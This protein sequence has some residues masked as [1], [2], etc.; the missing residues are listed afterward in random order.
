MALSNVSIQRQINYQVFHRFSRV[1]LRVRSPLLKRGKFTIKLLSVGHQLRSTQKAFGVLLEADWRLHHVFIILRHVQVPITKSP[2]CRMVNTVLL[3]EIRRL[4]Q[5]MTTAATAARAAA[6]CV[7]CQQLLL[8]SMRTAEKR[9]NCHG[10]SSM[11]MSA[12]V[13]M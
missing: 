10:S 3:A 8:T 13:I 2:R 4:S 7:V 5:P 1:G 9:H 6:A 12:A 11:S